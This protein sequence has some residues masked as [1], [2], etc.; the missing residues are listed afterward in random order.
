MGTEATAS[1]PILIDHTSQCVFDA[2]GLSPLY[3]SFDLFS[4]HGL[5]IGGF[6]PELRISLSLAHRQTQ[7]RNGS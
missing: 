2:S 6:P 5:V 7:V 1:N 3:P 4:K